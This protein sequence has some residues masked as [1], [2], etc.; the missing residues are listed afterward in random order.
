L[1]S[2][3]VLIFAKFML[4]GFA[5]LG[6]W[7]IVLTVRT[8]RKDAEP[9]TKKLAATKRSLLLSSWVTLAGIGN[10][11]NAIYSHQYYLFSAS[12]FL[13]SLVAPL[14]AL[15]FKTKSAIKNAKLS[16]RLVT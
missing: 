2:T 3:P 16:G 15:Y 1:A 12:A 6:I 10:A 13:L 9:D 4:T 7:S 11:V 14:F 5:G 8:L